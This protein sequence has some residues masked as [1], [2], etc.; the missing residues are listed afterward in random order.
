MHREDEQMNKIRKCLAV[1]VC[2][3][4]VMAV[5]PGVALAD[6]TTA[7][8]FEYYVYYDYVEITGYTGDATDLIIPEEIEGLP[9]TSIRSS[10]FSGY[11]G[12]TNVTIPNSVTSIDRSAFYGTAL[13]NDSANWDNGVFYIGDILIETR[14]KISGD[15]VIRPGTR[16]INEF[17]FD[18][19]VDLTSVS[20]PNSVKYIGSNAF[21]NCTGL[22]SMTI[23]NSV[24]EIGWRAFADCTG[25][26]GVTIENGVAGISGNA[27][28]G[29]TGL[30]D[31]TIPNSVTKIGEE[32]FYGCTSLKNVNIPNGI[33]EIGRSAFE[34]CTGITSLTIENGVTEIGDS[35]LKNC[36]GITNV[37]IPSSVTEIGYSAFEG[38]TGITNVIIPSSVTEIGGGAFSGCIGLTSVNIPDSVTKIGSGAFENTAICNNY[39][40]WGS[41]VLYINNNLIKARKEISG[42]Y[43][44]R[45]GT[46]T[47]AGGAF[48]GCADLT[49]ITIPE[50]VTSIG[51]FA[52]C[53]CTGLVSIKI[54][55]SVKE[56]GSSAFENC[57][58]LATVDF[59]NG[60][61]S[62]DVM[63][64]SDCVSLTSI[65][66]PD[67]VTHIGYWAFSDCTALADIKLPAKL[68]ELGNASFSNTAYY[69]DP[70][71]WVDGVLYNGD[72]IM[73]SMGTNPEYGPAYTFDS[74]YRIK[75][76][77]RVV[78]QAFYDHSEIKNLTVPAS[79]EAFVGNACGE[80]QLQ[81][82]IFEGNVPQIVSEMGTQYEFYPFG[83]FIDRLYYGN[84]FIYYPINN[85]TWIEELADGEFYIFNESNATFVP[86]DPSVG[87]E[88]VPDFTDPIKYRVY[89]DHVEITD[90]KGMASSLEIPAQIEGLPVTAI[91]DKAFEYCWSLEEVIL[92]NSVTDIGDWA[93]EY[94]NIKSITIPNS[95]THIGSG[96][97][98]GCTGL[99]S[100]NISNCATEISDYMFYGCTGLTDITVPN[101]VI[102]IG[103]NAFYGCTGLTNITIPNSVT[104]IGNSA[105][106]G[107]TGLSSVT[108]GSGVKEINSSFSG[109]T[110]L[111]NV[112]IPDSVTSI[113]SGI[114]DD[115]ALYNDNA[116]WDDGV[117][118]INNHL[119][120]AR[121][122]IS[123]DYIIRPGTCT[124]AGSAFSGCTGLTSVDIPE[125]VKEIGYNAF[126]N[127]TGLTSVT[128]PN[129]VAKIGD[130]AFSDCTGLISV[131]I[132]NGV[133]EISTAAFSGCTALLSVTIPSNVTMLRA[134]AFYGCTS[135]TDIYYGGN[136]G[137]SYYP[138]N[139]SFFN[140]QI[141]YDTPMS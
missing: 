123:G 31:V 64:F 104:S 14:Y 49:G 90:Y 28:K 82:L 73:N 25:L 60:L 43:I 42:D 79:V 62:I 72:I 8:G 32:A 70:A 17:V 85:Q 127:C 46:L 52:F 136:N 117:L 41:N 89:P 140:A 40:N 1:L 37:I 116:N 95:V 69:N 54:P 7:D 111:A 63:A 138:G 21:A 24:V 58:N 139:D 61:K 76:G 65:D 88:L 26:T 36:T 13:Y 2:M 91:G 134:S 47:I 110:S 108:I 131:S 68:V 114:F 100:V 56:I 84:V 83:Y 126:S 129:S 87:P 48:H 74:S 132:G 133:N 38:C 5:M 20:I 11:A 50:S 78:V 75:D 124:I 22:T 103:S 29:C 86:Y 59:G 101:S 30:T 12:L 96:A 94:S 98:Y 130:S 71:N 67:T 92:P 102:D 3:A 55:D 33:T 35:M 15:Y 18:N 51:N 80:L 122:E 19:C 66:I 128:I 125:S 112:T 53:N 81:R 23:P 113:Y 57:A 9:V 99:T 39:E 97:F 10:A 137:F 121:H 109:C 118:Y 105:F 34:G 141:H 107:C 44:I 93:F 6:G 16:I 106:S 4:M 115:T 77:T 27:F 45:P 119:I 135:L 120:A